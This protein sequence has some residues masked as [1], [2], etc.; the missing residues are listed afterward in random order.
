MAKRDEIIRKCYKLLVAIH[1]N[2]SSIISSVKQTGAIGR[3]IKDLEEQASLKKKKNIHI[4]FVFDSSFICSVV[5]GIYCVVFKLFSCCLFF[6]IEK[7]N[8]RHA[9]TNVQKL[10]TD[11]ELVKKEQMSLLKK[12]KN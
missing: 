5:I 2:S 7:E 1:S 8:A 4:V 6:Q 11:L 3:D 10:K 12:L 9:A